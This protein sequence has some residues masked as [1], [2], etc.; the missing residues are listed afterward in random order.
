MLKK[1]ITFIYLDRADYNMYQPIVK[2]AQKRGY[3]P[4]RQRLTGT[5][6]PHAL[7]FLP[8]DHYGPDYDRPSEKA[9]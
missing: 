5:P 9:R 1:D 6:F 4:R 3:L 2:E 7:T 8:E